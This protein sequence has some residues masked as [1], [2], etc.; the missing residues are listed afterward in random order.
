MSPG[1]FD[2]VL[3]DL[4]DTLIYFD[5]DWPVVFFQ[6]R[7]ALWDSLRADGLKLDQ[8]FLEDYTQQMLAYYQERD[9]EFIEYTNRYVLSKVLQEWGYEFVPERILTDALRE[10][11]RLT[12]AHWIPEKDAL[13]T[14]AKLDAL[15]YRMG[16]VSN[17][18]D[19]PNTQFLVDKLG[20][21]EYFEVILSSAA[22]GIRKPNPVIFHEALKRMKVDANRAVM[23]GDTLGADI[24][25]GKNAGIFSVWITRRA[26]TPANRSHMDTI[27]PDAQINTLGELIDLL[28][29]L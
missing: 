6:A 18:S 8:A 5:G 1:R 15:G 24:L 13:P 20:G 25:G 26:D 7:R 17:A 16:L 21:R 14:L 10:F 3:F 23:V 19:D 4:G 22:V 9:T 29:Q 28:A 11:H 2:V 27:L 12:Q